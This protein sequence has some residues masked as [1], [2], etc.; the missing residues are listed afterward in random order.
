MQCNLQGKLTNPKSA[1]LLA[2]VMLWIGRVAA[3]N[4]GK[5]DIVAAL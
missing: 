2:V 3:L 1:G 4:S 5:A